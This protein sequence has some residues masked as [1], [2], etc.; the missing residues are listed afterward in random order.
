MQTESLPYRFVTVGATVTVEPADDA[1]RRRIAARYLPA[2][3]V[4]GYLATGDVGEM[5]V[6]APAPRLVALQRLLTPGASLTH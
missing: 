5:V 3:V 2:A 1:I 6:P 4:D